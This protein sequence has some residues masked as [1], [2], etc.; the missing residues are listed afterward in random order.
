MD[1]ADRLRNLMGN[2]K[3]VNKELYSFSNRVITIT[4]GKGGVGKSNFTLNLGIQLIKQGKKVVIIDADFGLANIEVLFG[5]IPKK[6]LLNVLNGENSIKEVIT[7]GPMG[8]RFIS[9]GSGLSDLVNLT[10]RQLEQL[11]QS[12]SYLDDIADIIL[13]D[14]GAGAS[15][16]VIN[17]VKASN[18][19][20]ILTTPEPTAVTDAYSLIKMIKVSKFDIPRMSVVVNKIDNKKEGEDA[21]IRLNR[22]SHRFLGVEL[23]LLGYIPNDTLLVRAVK[24]QQPISILYPNASS[25][26]SI[27]RI[28]NDILNN[29]SCSGEENYGAKSFLNRFKDIFIK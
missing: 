6:S 8:L 23:K 18:E 19:A 2:K 16:H 26:K 9:G 27:A 22:V 12:F 28:S 11:L 24:Q 10:H 25:T 17:L 14:T 15:N 7:D 20:I 1:Q 29:N 5:A 13:I 4:S 21:Y 3:N